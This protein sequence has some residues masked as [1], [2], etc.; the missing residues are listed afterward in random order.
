MRICGEK[1]IHPM[2]DGIL[3]GI[4]LGSNHGKAERAG[5]DKL[6]LTFGAAKNIVSLQGRKGDVH[7]TGAFEPTAPVGEWK[8]AHARLEIFKLRW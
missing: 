5:F 8:T 2:G 4:D 6:D 3:K 1:S 7:L